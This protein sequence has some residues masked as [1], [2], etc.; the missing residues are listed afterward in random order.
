MKIKKIILFVILFIILGVVRV[1]ATTPEE[2]AI[3]PDFYAKQYI[4]LQNA[5][6]INSDLL[7]NH[8][9]EYGAREGRSSS[10]FFDVG[11]YLAQNL[12]VANA[13]NN[14]GQKAY[15]H[16]INYGLKEGRIASPF[17]DVN[18]YL[19]QNPDVKLA[20]T[21]QENIDY[22]AV[23]NHFLAY[24]MREGRKATQ[25][26]DIDYYIENNIDIKNAFSGDNRN[27]DVY[28]HFVYYGARE[29][30]TSAEFFDVRAY[31]EKY[32]DIKSAF[33]TNYFMAFKHYL[34]YGIKEGRFTYV[35][36]NLDLKFGDFVSYKP[37]GEYVWRAE[38]ATSNLTPIADDKKLA[39]GDKYISGT[40]E[41]MSI[42]CW[43]VLKVHDDGMVD[44]VASTGSGRKVLLQGPQG[45]NNGVQLLNDACDKLYSSTVTKNGKTYVVKARSINMDDI[46]GRMKKLNVD[47]D[48]NNKADWEEHRDSWKYASSAQYGQ[49]KEKAYTY[50]N[51]YPIIYNRE[52][53]NVI[54]GNKIES[55]LKQSEYPTYSDGTIKLFE[56]SE[57]HS[58]CGKVRASVSIKPY[59]TSYGI[60]KM[61]FRY[62]LKEDD[63][64]NL[65]NTTFSR[66]DDCY[67]ATRCITDF[68]SG[69]HFSIFGIHYGN[70]TYNEM[71]FSNETINDEYDTEGNELIPV[72]TVDS[73][74]ITKNSDGSFEIK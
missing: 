57:E 13:Y 18:Y 14:D 56:R 12:D 62:D 72:I 50:N 2:I 5:F 71:T 38:Y 26:L 29:G 28:N 42:F 43:T 6:G 17:F 11:Y 10:R 3:E 8:F 54:D 19:E 66:I 25:I 33:G 39:S 22:L 40:N 58:N 64:Y 36:E 31:L 23:Y 45:Y 4:D 49:Q 47:L 60:S 27:I 21:Y 53:N 37:S 30:R 48:N 20:Y 16:F 68:D 55:G 73:K 35:E 65:N 7:R 51:Y 46:E 34:I 44:L 9:I 70:L 67:I 15:Y 41:N 69:A 61:N 52:L 24:G 59:Q 63:N 74:A 1:Q 32:P